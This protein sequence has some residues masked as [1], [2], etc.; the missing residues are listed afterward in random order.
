MSSVSL[1][2]RIAYLVCD[3]ELR[4]PPMDNVKLDFL[5][6][7]THDEL[8]ELKRSFNDNRECLQLSEIS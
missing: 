4:M 8:R 7:Q 5:V 1:P 3:P 2:L 6:E